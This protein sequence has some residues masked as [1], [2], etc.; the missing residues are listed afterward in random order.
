VYADGR[1][2]DLTGA[3]ADAVYGS[4]VLPILASI[5]AEVVYVANVERSLIDPDGA[6]WSQ[7]AV[8]RY[9]SRA[10]LVAMLERQD[11]RDAAAHKVAGIER[12]IV[13]V[14]EP[15]EPSLPADLRRGDLSAVPFPPTPD[16]PP[17]TV[18]H[19]L[20]F[21]DIA[22]YADG[23]ETD[24]AGREAM[25]LYEQGR[26]PQAFP[27]GVR[28]GIVL[29]VEGELVGDGRPWEEVRVNNFPSRATFAQLITDESLE[30]AGIVHREAALADTY[31]L[32]AA[33]IVNGVGYLD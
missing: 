8:V 27:I 12:T 5:G 23:R 3:E 4:L 22:Q 10:Q 15:V 17:V 25:A 31:A 30:D 7:V 26:A 13:L 18:F 29:A 33:P 21:N 28:P 24:L 1:E 32:L 19:L 2:T 16:D 11:F 14:T 20:D 9:P 6:A